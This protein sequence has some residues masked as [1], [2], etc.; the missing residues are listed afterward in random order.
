M[1]LLI[2]SNGPGGNE[3]EDPPTVHTLSRVHTLDLRNIVAEGRANNL[4]SGKIHRKSLGKEEPCLR[5]TNNET[6]YE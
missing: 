6:M 3:G 1:A 5:K 2:A 4:T